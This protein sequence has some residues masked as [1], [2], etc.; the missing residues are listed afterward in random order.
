VTPL[1][2][3]LQKAGRAQVDFGYALAK[4]DETCVLVSCIDI[5]ERKRAEEA[6]RER[7]EV[8]RA[9][10]DQ[11]EEGIVLVDSEA[12]RFVE[13]NDAA[14]DSLGYSRE[15]FAHLTLLDVQ[16]NLPREEVA[17]RIRSILKEG[18]TH[19]E[20][21]QRRKDG[22]LRDVLVSN[23]VI[24]LRG[25]QYLAG[26]WQDITDRKQME[27]ERIQ[28]E[29]QLRQAQKI[30]AIGTL[31]GGIA[32]DFNNILTAILGY[33]ELAGLEIP[34]DSK[35]RYNLEQSIK[36]GRRAKDLVQQILAFSRQGKEERRPLNI[37]P[38]VKE[39]LKFLRASLPAT[40]EIRQ[41]MEEDPGT[42]EADP[43]QIHQILMNLC[44]NAAHAMGEKGGIIGVSLSNCTVKEGTSAVVAGP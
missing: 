26:I 4:F 7:E 20:N 29:T 10:V 35:A 8:Y 18:S 21:R 13:F 30:E 44:T 41:D 43:T 3:F 22:R 36:S 34:E 14:C 17:N 28:A 12:L 38:I 19:F 15:E 27:E 5:T 9:I 32:H 39:E 42:I 31:A 11:A 40:I 33:A 23:R 37:R 6:L 2:D 16:G 24:S 25:R 1:T